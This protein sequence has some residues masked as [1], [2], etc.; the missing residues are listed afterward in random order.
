M[1]KVHLIAIGGAVMHNLAIALHKK[2]MEITGSDNEI[3]DPSRER[4]KKYGLLPTRTGWFPENIHAQLD[5]VITGMHAKKD[6]PELLKARELD[7][8][9]YSFPEFVFRQ[10]K[11][12]QRIVIGGSHGKTTITAMVMHVL[13]KAGKDF[14]YLVG[15]PVDGFD[16]SVK[17]TENTGSIV[18][19]GDEYLSSPLDQRPKFLHYHPHI[20]LL[21]GISWDHINVFPT[22]DSYLEAFRE[23]LRTMKEGSL[24]IYNQEDHEL[25]SMV[26]EL[27]VNIQLVPY[28]MPSHEIKKGKLILHSQHGNFPL[29]L[30]GVHNLFNLE[31]ARKICALM[32]IA[33]EVFYRYIMDFKGAGK[34][35]ELITDRKKTRIFKDFAHAPSKVKAT[36]EGLKYQFA[37]SKL[38]AVLELHTYSSLNKDFL[39]NYYGT[40][41]KAD[42]VLVFVDP[43]AVK[44]KKMPGLTEE[45]IKQ[46]FG[47]NDLR[48]FFSKAALVEALSEKRRGRVNFVFMSSGN[49]N[50]LNI[51]NIYKLIN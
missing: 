50:G 28:A 51:N 16:D 4:L 24:L 33:S 31:G 7:L 21:T 30:F 19:E 11:D 39:P 32:G 25:Y 3:F 38:A 29:S 45:D 22:Y 40:T 35:L 17:L 43:E 5:A 10:C 13:K 15:A 27:P 36:L 41:Q 44:L 6:N 48:V 26:E 23:F 42:E 1:M 37:H 34:R 2:G 8:P 47:R 14:D 46:A 18:M 12:K 20:A 49:F 9:V